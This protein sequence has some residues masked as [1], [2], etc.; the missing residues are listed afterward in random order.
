MRIVDTH[1]HL[2]YLDKFSY[3]WLNSVPSLQCQWDWS[4]YWTEARALGIEA[5]IHMEVDVTEDEIDDET[6]FVL[7]VDPHVIGAISAARPERPDFVRHLEA[8]GAFADYCR[9]S[10]TLFPPPLYS[11]RISGGWQSTA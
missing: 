10:P 3:P 11:A 1:L 2:I 6:R 4:S 8:S 9:T 7:G 5:A